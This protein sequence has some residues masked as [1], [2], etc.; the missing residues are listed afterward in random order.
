MLVIIFTTFKKEVAK[1]FGYISCDEEKLT[2]GER[3]IIGSFYC[4]L[5]MALKTHFGN[6]ARFFTN[7]DCTYAFMLISSACE[8]TI[9]LERKRCALHPLSKRSITF[10]DESFSQAIASATILISYYKLLD[11]CKD[12][13][14]N[15]TKA[16]MRKFYKKIAQKAQTILPNFDADLRLN[17]RSTQELERQNG[18]NL[19]ELMHY[20]GQI[21][22]SMAEN[23]GA[24]ALG[25]LFYHMGRLVYFFDALDDYESDIKKRRF[26]AIKNR[27]GVFNDKTQLFLS[28]FAEID[29]IFQ[30][31]YESLNAEYAVLRPEDSNPIFDNLFSDGIKSCYH[32]IHK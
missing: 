4:G 12:E 21:L 22:K 10:V 31:I 17:S 9:S 8:T 14:R 13:K 15:L 25:T 20:S 5:C 16:S 26:N 30:G 29:A 18:D 27:F 19:D 11:D 7:I 23:C 2:A 3:N 28:K 32:K 1:M 6:K 24:E